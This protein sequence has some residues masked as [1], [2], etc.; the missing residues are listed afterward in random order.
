MG[1]RPLQI[2]IPAL[3]FAQHF[4]DQTEMIYHGLNSSL[5]MTLSATASASFSIATP[6]SEKELSC[7]IKGSITESCTQVMTLRLPH[8]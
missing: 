6:L 7:F 8:D 4:L 3:Q 5:T 1:I 2:P